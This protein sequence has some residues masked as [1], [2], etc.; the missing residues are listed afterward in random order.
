MLSY[1][2]L[3]NCAIQDWK[4]IYMEK[5]KQNFHPPSQLLCGKT[6]QHRNTNHLAFLRTESFTLQPFNATVFSITIIS[7]GLLCTGNVLQAERVSRRRAGLQE[8][9]PGPGLHGKWACFASCL[10]YTDGKKKKNPASLILWCEDYVFLSM[11][12]WRCSVVLTAN[13]RVGSNVIQLPA[14]GQG[15]LYFIIQ[16]KLCYVTAP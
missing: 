15:L 4:L 1:P 8:A 7:L 6:S 11:Q 9:G 5:K 16:N 14:A 10:Q 13:P 3:C 12:S 2:D